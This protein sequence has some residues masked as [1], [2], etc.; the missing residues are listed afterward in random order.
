VS[1]FWLQWSGQKGIALGYPQP[2]VQIGALPSSIRSQQSIQLSANGSGRGLVY[3]WTITPSSE[4][5]DSS[6]PGSANGQ[7]IHYS[8]P[9]SGTYTVTV[10]AIDAIGNQISD[11][12]QVQVLPI[13]PVA[14]FTAED[15]SGF[16]ISVSCNASL[17]KADPGTEIETYTWDF[18]DGSEPEST[19]YYSTSHDYDK[20]GTYTITLVV[21][22]ETGQQSQ[23]VSHS[24][25]VTN[26]SN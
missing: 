16:F 5:N 14:F 7:S 4:N 13:P 6:E 23:P 1:L 9:S 18:G 2:T 15:S 17:S 19:S 8:F 3:S 20:A 21:T 24:V 25:T 22:D 11:K 26:K 12:K 10:T